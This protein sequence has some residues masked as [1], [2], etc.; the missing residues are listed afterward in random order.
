[1]S[2]FNFK[3]TSKKAKRKE[4]KAVSKK[5][6][7]E[8]GQDGLTF[9]ARFQILTKDRKYAEEISDNYVKNMENNKDAKGNRKYFI[10]KKIIDAPRKLKKDEM[11]GI[12]QGAGK[13]VFISMLDLDVSTK[14][15]TNVF[16]F[17]FEYMPFFIEIISPM[18]INFTA[19]ELTNY[20]T[21]I[22]STIHKIDEGLKISK[23]RMEDVVNKYNIMSKNVVRLLRNNIILSLKEKDKDLKIIS[24]N[25]GIPE[26]QL[27]PFL[28][29]MIKDN[30]IKLE[31]NKYKTVK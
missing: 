29:N 9:N 1:M 16:D 10:I 14:K 5:E 25:V 30:E 21:S 18:N 8:P 6:E 24:E 7:S 28:D 12:P 11:E 22:Q 31:E 20:I 19:N 26:N 15:K 3:K 17:C 27:K 13:N 4:E 23:L 2:L